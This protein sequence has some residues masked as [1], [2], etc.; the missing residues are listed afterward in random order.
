MR[1]RFF[2]SV[3]ATCCTLPGPDNATSRFACRSAN[4]AVRDPTTSPA[5]AS[6]SLPVS[7]QTS[8]ICPETYQVLTSLY[9]SLWARYNAAQSDF[10]FPCPR[11]GIHNSLRGASNV[12]DIY[13]CSRQS[14]VLLGNINISYSTF[15]FGAKCSFSLFFRAA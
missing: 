4:V 6:R 7:S 11:H 1:R 8:V 13:L 5:I 14:L 3:A 12:R 15:L 10:L 2:R 9:P